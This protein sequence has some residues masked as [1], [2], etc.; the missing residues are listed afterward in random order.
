MKRIFSFILS[1]AMVFVLDAPP[2]YVQAYVMGCIVGDTF[3]PADGIA[4]NI[5]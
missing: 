3:H 2:Q 1:V 5:S 4:K